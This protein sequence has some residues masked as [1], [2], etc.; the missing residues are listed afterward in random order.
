MTPD[1]AAQKVEI[2]HFYRKGFRPKGV[3]HVGAN[4]GYEIEFYLA[5]GCKPILAFEPLHSAV[6][7]LEKRFSGNP[8]VEFIPAALG[9][10]FSIGSLKIAQGDGMGSTFLHE[11]S[12]Q[13][14]II[15]EQDSPIF[16]FD[17]HLSSDNYNT[18]VL[19]VQGMELQV[20][21][22][23]GRELPKLD[24][25]NVECSRVPLFEGEPPA[26][27]II[28]YLAGKGFRQDSPILDHGDIRFIHER[29]L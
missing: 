18:L 11:F 5:M 29:N 25:L 22:G 27:T 19:D 16:R 1:E 26:Q 4:D 21:E 17:E 23:F 24:F 8:D 6:K 28:E 2:G 7:E 10:H 15:G 3:I 14:S 13:Y 9:D 20:L 12:Q